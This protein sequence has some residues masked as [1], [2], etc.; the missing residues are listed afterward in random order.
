MAI[1]GAF[2]GGGLGEIYTPLLIW[3]SFALGATAGACVSEFITPMVSVSILALV[4]TVLTL[5]TKY[6]QTYPQKL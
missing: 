6:T 2:L 4:M 3:M 5:L 1:A